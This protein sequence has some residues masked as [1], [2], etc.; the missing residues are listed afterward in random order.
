[1]RLHDFPIEPTEDSLSFYII[2]A[3]HHIKPSSMKS[4]LSGIIQQLEPLYPNLRNIRNSL[5]IRCTLQGCLQL[6]GIATTRKHA[7][8]VTDLEKVQNNLSTST[9]QDDL[10]F[11]AMLFTGFSSLL[12]L[13]EMTFLDD[14]TLHNW[15]KV[16]QRASVHVRQDGYEFF[17]PGHKADRFFEG[18]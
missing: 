7:L 13:G 2:Y 16:I 8:R 9:S 3:S 15:K 14:N 12:R 18:N 1:M 4:Y 11:L 17:L 6:R 5:L 10:L